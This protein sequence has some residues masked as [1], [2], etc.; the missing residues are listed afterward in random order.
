MIKN[1]PKKLKKIKKE[2]PVF[3]NLYLIHRYACKSKM[4]TT[5]IWRMTYK[6]M[7]NDNTYR[8]QITHGTSDVEGNGIRYDFCQITQF[9]DLFTF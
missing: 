2:R 5:Y 3:V 4:L 1:R 6:L 9:F 8:K 7:E